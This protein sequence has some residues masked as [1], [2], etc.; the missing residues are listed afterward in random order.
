MKKVLR[1][2]GLECPNCAKKL[3]EALRPADGVISVAVNY[4]TG[5]MT[6]EADDAKMEAVLALALAEGKKIK[7][8]FEFKD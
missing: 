5:K 6:L 7:P 2:V 4:L 8:A 3:E 1:F